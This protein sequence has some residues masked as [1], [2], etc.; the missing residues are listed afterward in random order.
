MKFSE[1]FKTKKFAFLPYVCLGYPTLEKSL[2]LVRAL[3]PYADGF[4]LGIPF[5]DPVADGP[6]LQKA[7][8]SALEAGFKVSQTFD[9]VRVVR[10]FTQK[11]I[12]IMTYLNPVLAHG[13]QR[14]VD[15]A[16][17]TGADALII[18]DA[19]M[20]EIGPVQAACAGK[21]EVPLFV[22]PTTP[23]ARA[24]KIAQSA[25]GFIYG[26]AIKGVTGARKE[27]E[28]DGM[29]ADVKALVEK[30]SDMGF[31]IPVVFG[32]GISNAK[33][34]KAVQNAGAAG[35]IIGSRIVQAYEED[36]L[37]GV[38]TWVQ[39]LTLKT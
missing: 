37:E 25:Q 6:V 31:Q 27:T 5:S 13:L 12:A 22:T 26:I 29:G 10:R 23:K 30:T 38:K 28:M 9:A 24:G 16:H 17:A 19:P 15:E 11:P 2:D 18:P 32:F 4:E 39:S 35:F 34:A 33:H 21:L 7:A 3:E 36:G 8:Q 20:E 1:L 14:F